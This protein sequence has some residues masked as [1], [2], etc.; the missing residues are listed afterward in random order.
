MSAQVTDDKSSNYD[1]AVAE[2]EDHKHLQP[3]AGLKSFILDTEE[4]IKSDSIHLV[5]EGVSDALAIFFSG[6]AAFQSASTQSLAPLEDDIGNI[7]SAFCAC[8]LMY[9]LYR[10]KSEKVA[11]FKQALELFIQYEDDLDEFGPEKATE[12]LEE[13]MSHAGFRYVGISSDVSAVSF[14]PTK[15]RTLAEKHGIFSKNT[16]PNTIFKE[17]IK[18]V[19]NYL[20]KP[21]L[22]IAFDGLQKVD[23]ALHGVA[24]ASKF[25]GH[26]VGDIGANFVLAHRVAFDTGQGLKAAWYLHATE[27]NR[28]KLARE[29]ADAYV[30]NSM[31]PDQLKAFSLEAAKKIEADISDDQKDAI[32]DAL[33]DLIKLRKSSH[34]SKR[35]LILQ[36]SYISFQVFQSFYSGF[37]GDN[38]KAGLAAFSAIAAFGPLSGF[39][40]ELS[41][42]VG[43]IDSKRSQK[44]ENLA[45]I[46]QIN[47]SDNE[48]S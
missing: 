27:Y 41:R 22:D 34:V 40:N 44:V 39:A 24:N 11:E 8:L 9:G 23:G 12:N 26:I 1:L 5:E 15:Y 2:R 35:F 42:K 25:A 13:K 18:N 20:C 16:P 45:R 48:P 36:M 32:R 47:T 4:L 37:T 6:Q 29:I 3:L 19:R 10:Q 30:N 7:G 14:R 31:T 38:K 28:Q 33:R 17:R 46:L 21:K 43:K